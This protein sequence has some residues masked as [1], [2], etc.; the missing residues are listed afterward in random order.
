MERNGDQAHA[1]LQLVYGRAPWKR[2]D[3]FFVYLRYL[4]GAVHMEV[5]PRIIPLHSTQDANT[6]PVE[7]VLAVASE[8][9]RSDVRGHAIE[10]DGRLRRRRQ[11]FPQL[12]PYSAHGAANG[13]LAIREY[14]LERFLVFHI[15]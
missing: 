14:H 12:P 5:D 11:L 3:V 7:Q 2:K 15:E 1:S 10:L 9:K 13:S 4:A 6:I 8:G